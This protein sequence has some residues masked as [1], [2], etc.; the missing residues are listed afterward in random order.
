MANPQHPGQKPK[1]DRYDEPD[2]EKPDDTDRPE[3]KER[4]CPD[5]PA[6]PKPPGLE[7]PETCKPR[8]DCPSPPPSTETCFDKLIAEQAKLESE[9]AGAK[10]FKDELVVL[11]NE[12]KAARK[13]YTREKYEDFKKRWRKQDE[14]ILGAI[15]IVICNVKCWWCVI[16]CEIC[17]LLYKIREI[18]QRLH[19]S[20][21]E[22]ITQAFSERD[23]QYWHE[24][25]VE[26]KT[27]QL[28]RIKK[29]MD[30]WKAPATTIEAALV[31][32]EKTLRSLRS[33]DPSEQLLQVF[34]KLIPLHLAVAPRPVA[35]HTR[36]DLKYRQLCGECDQGAPEYCCGPN[37]GLL[38]ARQRL[39]GPHAY[40]VD[41]NEFFDILCCLA[42]ERYRPAKEQLAKANSEL[43]A[44]KA[45]IDGLTK[46]LDRRRASVFDDYRANIVTPIDCR[47][48]RRNGGDGCPRDDDEQPDDPTVS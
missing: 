44:V 48:Y 10:A 20:P 36:I 9:A 24:R 22:L 27:R 17:P 40:I 18:E 41:P 12:A 14:E 1:D 5:L 32:N 46:E 11:L 3:H 8:C 47:K 4:K 26:A 19:G 2:D 28:D 21:N 29:V 7:P 43:I 33:L 37:T 39:T 23:L 13:D 45:R 16:E 30:A 15:D 31:D 34:F 6:G 42:T 35:D 38:S 25:N